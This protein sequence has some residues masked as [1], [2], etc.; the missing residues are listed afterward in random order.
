MSPNFRK[1]LFILASCI[2]LLATFTAGTVIGMRK[3]QHFDRWADNYP[4][5]FRERDRGAFPG[6]LVPPTFPGAHG[7]FGRVISVAEPRVVV[8]GRDG[9]EQEVVAT[10]S[11]LIRIGRREGAFA[12]I[13]P[14]S[15]AA[16]FGAPNDAGQIEAK[17]IRVM[18][19]FFR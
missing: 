15:E 5:M 7:V 2:V 12:D 6:P 1:A 18:D 4:R 16:V 17:L 8:E 14:D 13:R 19:G 10:S 11:T 9:V 3:A